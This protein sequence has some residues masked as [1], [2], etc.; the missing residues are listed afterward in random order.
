MNQELDYLI[1]RQISLGF[2]KSGRTAWFGHVMRMEDYRISQIV[3]L[4]KPEGR[5]LKGRPRKRRMEDI[6]I[7]EI[8]EWKSLSVD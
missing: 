8:R 2:A 3:M 1:K 7:M 4:W 5:R 6:K